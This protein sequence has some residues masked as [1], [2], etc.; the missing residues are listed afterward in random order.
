MSQ[1]D[2]KI[3]YVQ[4]DVNTVADALSRLP[5]ETTKSSTRAERKA[6]GPWDLDNEPDNTLCVVLERPEVSPADIAEG[7][8]GR[9]AVAATKLSV[10]ADKKFLEAIRVGYNEDP[11][12]K[13]M[14]SV[15]K[16]MAGISEKDGL[17]FLAHDTLGHFGTDKTYGSL[18][19]A[20]Y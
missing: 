8:T 16:G 19:D 15:K 17:W 11:W 13:K 10:S 20:Y 5:T 9:P 6:P 18:R 2:C 3:V 7:L 14:K 4:G 12:T 1:Y